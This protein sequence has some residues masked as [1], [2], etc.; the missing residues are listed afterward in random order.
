MKEV[1]AAILTIKKPGNMTPEGR[2]AIAAWL[3]KEAFHLLKYGAEYTSIK[4][5]TASYLYK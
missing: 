5:Y 1:S 2:K 3:K 4:K